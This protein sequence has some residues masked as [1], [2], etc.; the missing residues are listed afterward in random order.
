[1]FRAN[2]E[3]RLTGTLFIADPTGAEDRTGGQ[4][5]HF[6]PVPR[7]ASGNSELQVIQ[8]SMHF[9][10]HKYL[11]INFFFFFGV[12]RSLSLFRLLKNSIVSSVYSFN[13]I[14]LVDYRNSNVYVLFKLV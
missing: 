4:E 12:L 11:D 7:G 10:N 2:T 5:G 14:V 6:V 13:L 8:F 9:S 3:M 1:M